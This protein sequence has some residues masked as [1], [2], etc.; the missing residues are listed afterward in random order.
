VT[1]KASNQASPK[2]EN[3][4]LSGEEQAILSHIA[5]QESPYSPRA[6]ALL[7]I[8][9]GVTQREAGQQAGLTDGQVRY[10]LIKFR[11]SRTAIFPEELLVPAER[12]ET[13]SPLNAAEP[14]AVLDKQ[15]LTQAGAEEE[16]QQEKSKAEETAEPTDD[17]T[18]LQEESTM[19]KKQSKQKQLYNSIFHNNSLGRKAESSIRN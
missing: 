6:Q 13:G 10:W 7:A 3:K 16:G 1:T 19:A 12:A 5:S 11:K 2:N 15:D 9:E 8:N 14:V 18:T 17:P 4:L